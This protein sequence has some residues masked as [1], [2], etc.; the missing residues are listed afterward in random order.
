MAPLICYDAAFTAQAAEVARRGAQ[1][2][3]T[4]SNDSW[5]ADTPAPELHL[6]VSAFR[7]VETR[8][9]QIRAANS[10]VSAVID[11]TGEIRARTDFGTRAVLS[12]KVSP[13]TP[14]TTL[15]ARWGDW[16]GPVAL[17]GAIALIAAA[18]ARFR[19]GFNLKLKSDRLMG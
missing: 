6:I 1:L 19:R 16:L 11:A 4:L 5:F 7:S 2:L 8:L 9:P 14:P 15:V 17:A 10:G 12:S 18:R 3:V 13:S